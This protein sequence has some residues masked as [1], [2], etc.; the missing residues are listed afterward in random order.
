VL[1]QVGLTKEKDLPDVPLMMDLATNDADRA[2]LRVLSTPV[3]LSKQI[4]TSPGVPAERVDAL[5]KAFDETMK[6][7][8]FLAEAAKERLDINPVSGA[9]M[10]KL[11]S[12][13]IANTP[14]DAADRLREIMG[15][16]GDDVSSH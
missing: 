3:M 14:K 1:T 2:V 15:E 16:A 12:D 9:D 5:R 8:Q 13:M 4:F 10:Q 6:D 7:P 11:V